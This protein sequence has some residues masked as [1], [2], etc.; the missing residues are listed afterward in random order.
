MEITLARGEI[1]LI[2]DEDSDLAQ[3]KWRTDK[4]GY[5]RR[6]SWKILRGADE[7]MHRTVMSRVV[8]YTLTPNE[9]VDHI[10]N[11]PLNNVR[12]NLRL[13]T[14]AQNGANR[15]LGSNSTSGYK[16]VT[17]SKA[18]SKWKAHI[19][20]SGKTKHLGYFTDV[21][22]AAQAYNE[23]AISYFGEFALINDLG[24]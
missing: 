12:S 23:A 24:G 10:D 17:W 2:S 20:V 4:D 16:G 13:A 6:R 18:D 3:Y 19:M 8:G 1:A 14:T 21:L 22:Q 15:R 9:K 11:N 5:A 7:R